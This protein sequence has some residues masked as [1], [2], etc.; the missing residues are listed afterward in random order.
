MRL[1]GAALPWHTWQNPPAT[2]RRTCSWDT[3]PIQYFVIIVFLS[4]ADLK[5][6]TL[7]FSESA[8]CFLG[9]QTAFRLLENAYPTL[10]AAAQRQPHHRHGFAVMRPRFNFAPAVFGVHRL[11]VGRVKIEFGQAEPLRFN[12]GVFHQMPAH[13]APACFGQHEHVAQPVF[14]LRQ[15]GDVVPFQRGRTEQSP[16]VHRQPGK[17]QVIAF[18]VAGVIGADF[19]H[20]LPR[21]EI[22]PF[23]V[24]GVGEG[25]DVLRLFR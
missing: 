23:G 5:Q 6:P 2:P 21:G 18:Q 3:V 17:R 13:A 8:G 25:V 1:S 4:V 11:H 15:R 7:G 16:T 10:R 20:V 14:V 12:Q 24:Q 19:F 22:V 9:F